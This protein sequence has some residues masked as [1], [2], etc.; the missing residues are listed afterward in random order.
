[1]QTYV[2][3]FHPF[4][5]GVVGGVEQAVNGDKRAGASDTGRAVRQH[6]RVWTY[7]RGCPHDH[8]GEREGKKEEE[9]KERIIRGNK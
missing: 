7:R 5:A 9:E 3:D 1:M 2:E 6:G 8:A 4:H